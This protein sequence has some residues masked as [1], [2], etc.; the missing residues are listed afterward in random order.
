MHYRAMERAW[1]R[2]AAYAHLTTGVTWHSLRHAHATRLLRAGV[3]V[4]TV[5]ARLGHSSAAMTM[6]V[7]AHALPAD[8]TMAA[9]IAVRGLGSGTNAGPH[10][11]PHTPSRGLNSGNEG[12]KR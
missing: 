10:T 5:Q 2:M 12:G 11:S 4:K 1:R 3:P 7:Y 9:A 6:E 8:D